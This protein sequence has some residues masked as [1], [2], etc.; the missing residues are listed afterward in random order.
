MSAI[1]LRIELERD[2]AAEILDPAH[3]KRKHGSRH[4]ADQGCKGPLCR[5]ARNDHYRERNRKKRDAKNPR[6]SYRPTLRDGILIQLQKNY[7]ASRKV[8]GDNF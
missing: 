2:V 7:E 6:P 8:N 1:E 4:T 5:K 3:R